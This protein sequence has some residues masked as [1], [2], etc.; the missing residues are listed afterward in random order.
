MLYEYDARQ[1]KCPLP[2]VKT[3]VLLKK[4]Q[5]GDNCLVKLC[6]QGSI[7]DIPKL[8][9]KQGYSFSQKKI[10]SDTVELLISI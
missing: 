2:L 1:D 3:R 10:D 8:L 7:R 6:D 9:V 5:E 4:M